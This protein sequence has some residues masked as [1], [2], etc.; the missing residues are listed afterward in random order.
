MKTQM[1]TMSNIWLTRCKTSSSVFH[2]PFS[3]T[4][5]IASSVHRKQTSSSCL[6]SASEAPEAFPD[7]QQQSRSKATRLV[8]LLHPPDDFQQGHEQFS[9]LIPV[10]RASTRSHRNKREAA[11]PG[12]QEEE[13]RAVQQQPFEIPQLWPALALELF[14][15]RP[16]RSVATLP[17]YTCWSAGCARIASRK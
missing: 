16:I 15:P 5:Y 12:E 17:L 14:P 3:I 13:Q 4:K 7:K 8:R 2:P 6:E 9:A 1:T 10:K 11:E